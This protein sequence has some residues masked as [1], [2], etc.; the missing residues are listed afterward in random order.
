[1]ALVNT[2]KKLMALYFGDVL[3]G[4]GGKQSNALLILVH[5]PWLWFIHEKVVECFARV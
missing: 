2:R 1:M 4:V 3:R 5:T